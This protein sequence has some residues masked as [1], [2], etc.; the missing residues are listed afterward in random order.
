MSRLFWKN[1]SA[2]A[3]SVL[4]AVLLLKSL[5]IGVPSFSITMHETGKA[6]VASQSLVANK[7]NVF[8]AGEVAGE[9]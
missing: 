9:M 5:P 4:G 2:A 7:N 3:S 1:Q 8:P 6:S